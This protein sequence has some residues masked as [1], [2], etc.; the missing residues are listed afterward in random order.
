MRSGRFSLWLAMQIEHA[1]ILLLGSTESRDFRFLALSFLLGCISI[2][3]ISSHREKI[4]RAVIGIDRDP[5]TRITA[6]HSFIGGLYVRLH[7]GYSSS[8]TRILEGVGTQHRRVIPCAPFSGKWKEYWCSEKTS[9]TSGII[10]W[11]LH[12]FDG[13]LLWLLLVSCLGIIGVWC[14]LKKEGRG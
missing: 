9:S 4:T 6:R 8:G 7:A 3:K 11:F 5:R 13:V 1:N 14:Y 2:S 12:F 10:V